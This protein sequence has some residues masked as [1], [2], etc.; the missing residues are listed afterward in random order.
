MIV[1]VYVLLI[2]LLIN[3]IWECYSDISIIV[4]TDPDVIVGLPNYYKVPQNLDYCLRTDV[5]TT[6]KAIQICSNLMQLQ[7]VVRSN[8]ESEAIYIVYDDKILETKSNIT[9]IDISSNSGG[10]IY[11]A[12]LYVD[13]PKRGLMKF[14]A[15]DI[16]LKYQLNSTAQ[17]SMLQVLLPD[18]I[19]QNINNSTDFNLDLHDGD[20]F[21]RALNAITADE[22]K[23]EIFKSENFFPESVDTWEVFFR[24]WYLQA[25][26]AHLLNGLQYVRDHHPRVYSYYEPMAQLDN[27]IGNPYVVPY[28]GIQATPVL[29]RYIIDAA[30]IIDQLGWDEW[31]GDGKHIIEIGGGYGGMAVLLSNIF[32]NIQLYSIVD[33]PPAGVLQLKY[34]S[35]CG[36]SPS[37]SI[38]AISSSSVVPVHSDILLSFY[39]ISELRK[40]IVDRYLLV[41]ISHAT[42]G[43][44]QLN[45]DEEFGQSLTNFVQSSNLYTPNI[46]YEKILT[47]HPLALLIP[48]PLYTNQTR[49]VW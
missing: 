37:T 47:Y 30:L 12:I 7:F 19:N 22:E 13:V 45:Y 46:L 35:R 10:I 4:E 20:A 48:G 40:D 34:T 17:T 6:E 44:L 14:I 21:I 25:I 38:Q 5:F 26:Q 16:I 8:L 2:V 28:L 39:A 18:E 24:F 23:F 41:Y 27:S 11:V 3:S 31:T 33:I 49:I 43:Y 36:I 15:N 29:V 42:H 32:P 9:E 1:C